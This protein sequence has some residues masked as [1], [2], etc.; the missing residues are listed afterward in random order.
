MLPLTLALPA[1]MGLIPILGMRYGWFDAQFGCLLRTIADVVVFSAV[2]FVVAMQLNRMQ[3]LRA[4]AEEKFRLA[5]E[6][7]PAP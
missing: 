1:V 2:V 4:Q 6:S 7:C 3:S 5:V